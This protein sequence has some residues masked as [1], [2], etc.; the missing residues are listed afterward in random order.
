M[1]DAKV[2]CTSK[3]RRHNVETNEAH[4][5]RKKVKK[6]INFVDDEKEVNKRKKESGRREPTAGYISS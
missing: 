4:R 6:G 5:S 1:V 2:H 3:L